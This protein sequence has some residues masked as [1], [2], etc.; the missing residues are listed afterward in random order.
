M[1]RADSLEKTLM[2]GK[3][4]SRRRRGRQRMRW[5]DGITASR[6][7]VWVDSGSWWWTQR[8]GMWQLMGSQR[9]RHDWATELN[10][11]ERGWASSNQLK[12]LRAKTEVS[13]RSSVLRLQHV[14]PAW[15]S[16]LQDC[17]ADCL[18]P[19][20]VSQFLKISLSPCIH[21][22]TH[23][24][25]FLLLWR[26]LTNTNGSNFCCCYIK[27]S[28]WHAKKCPGFGSRR[29]RFKLISAL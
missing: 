9:V 19:T 25:L 12:T 26:M 3:I 11:I 28:F 29:Y 17:L 7:W 15:V 10:W 1:R 8:P 16:S 21:T 13:W 14:N 4:E 23:F 6:T 5:L 2:L 22:H 20:I 27:A 24:L 18:C